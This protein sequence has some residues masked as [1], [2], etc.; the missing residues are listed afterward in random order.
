MTSSTVMLSIIEDTNYYLDVYAYVC[1]NHITFTNK[2]NKYM[3]VGT[4]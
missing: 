4:E 3:S 1:V 2:D